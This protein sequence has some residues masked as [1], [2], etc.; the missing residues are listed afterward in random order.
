MAIGVTFTEDKFD[1]PAFAAEPFTAETL[2]PGGAKII[3][4]AFGYRD[5]LVVTVGSGGAAAD[6]TSVP[7]AIASPWGR[8]GLTIP[9][10][11]QLDFGGDKLVITTAAVAQTATALPVRALVAAVSAND[12]ATYQGAV[13]IKPIPAGT[14]VGRTFVERDANTGF[15]VADTSTPDDQLFLTAF[16]VPDALKRNDIVLLRHT[17]RIYED[18]LP[19]WAGLSSGAKTA[20]RARYQCIKSA[21]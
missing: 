1:I 12:V 3:A 20:I 18:K 8:T 16:E 6:A 14:L 15:G 9:A 4:S 5:A 11:T 7:V 21:Q 17:T 2:M 10:G 19:G 13:M